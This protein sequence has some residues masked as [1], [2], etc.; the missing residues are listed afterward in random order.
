MGSVHLTPAYV[1]AYREIIVEPQQSGLHF[2]PLRECFVEGVEVVP[3]H[4]LY[5]Q[6]RREVP[7]CPKVIFYLVMEQ[8]YVGLLG[9]AASGE[10]GCRVRFVEGNNKGV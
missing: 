3:M 2:R 4:V 1:G 9:K 8:E 5:E 7:G 10:Y 6:Y